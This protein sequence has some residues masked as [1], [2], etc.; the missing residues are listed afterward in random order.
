MAAPAYVPQ[1]CARVPVH[2]A[3][4]ARIPLWV[5]GVWA[6]AVLMGVGPRCAL[7]CISLRIG[8]VEHLSMGLLAIPVSSLEKRLFRSFACF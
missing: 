5:P 8:G 7:T 3:P 6:A 2:R 1:Q 4:P